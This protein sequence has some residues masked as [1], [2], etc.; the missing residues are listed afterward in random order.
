MLGAHVVDEALL[1]TYLVRRKTNRKYEVMFPDWGRGLST[2][3]TIDD[4]EMSAEKTRADVARRA[5]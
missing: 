1:F 3:R 4:Y 5:K 2:L